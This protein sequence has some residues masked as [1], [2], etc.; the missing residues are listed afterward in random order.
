MN[1]LLDMET[2]VMSDLV[3]RIKESKEISSTADWQI[4]RL[5]M[6]NKSNAEIKKRLKELLKYSKS[7]INKLYSDTLEKSYVRDLSLYNA[8]NVPAVPFKS[9]RELQAIIQAYRAQTEGEFVNITQTIGFAK[10]AKNDGKIVFTRIAEYYQ[11]TLDGAIT[12]IATGTFDYNTVLKR[13]VNEMTASGLRTA[14]F[15]SGKSFRIETA[16]RTALMTGLSQTVAKMN[17]IV[18]K[19]LGTDFYEIDWH[20]GARP[21]HQIW[22]G[23]VWSKEQLVTVC[24][25]GTVTGLCGAN[26]YHSYFPF[27]KGA[28]VRNYTDK[29]LDELNSAENKP[30][31]YAGKKYTTYQATQRQRQ[32]ETLMRKQRQEINLLKKGGAGDEEIKTA[33]A[34]YQITSAQYSE[35]SKVMGIPQ[36]RDRVTVDGLKRV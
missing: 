16:V 15:A 1:Y 31:T 7:E 18:A 20:G 19:D 36:Q 9:N 22:Q 35:F 33:R 28:S 8:L 13:V 5:K 10:K 14:T 6:L 12:D 2:R 27:V 34:R 26:C 23:K 30:K 17:D 32:M 4:N 11:K 21:S 3:Q 29:Q 25:L 24:G